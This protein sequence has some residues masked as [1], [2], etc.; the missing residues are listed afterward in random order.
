LRGF[1]PVREPAAGFNRRS[2]EAGVEELFWRSPGTAVAK[3]A[4]L[5]VD[6]VDQAESCIE[7]RKLDLVEPM[8]QCKELLLQVSFSL[9]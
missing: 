5:R 7:S 1:L 4:A 2:V 8:G 6:A 3:Q 9:T